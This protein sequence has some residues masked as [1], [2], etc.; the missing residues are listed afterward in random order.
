MFK[1]Q[2]NISNQTANALVAIERVRA[3]GNVSPITAHPND[4]ATIKKMITDGKS[5]LIRVSGIAHCVGSLFLKLLHML[6]DT[7]WKDTLQSNL[8]IN[9]GL[10]SI[11][12]QPS[13]P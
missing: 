10:S 1:P 9:D 3:S 11:K 8:T 6:S 4:P 7:E 13:T 2:F 5:M 12:L